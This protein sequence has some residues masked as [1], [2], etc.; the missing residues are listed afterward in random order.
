MTTIDAAMSDL[1]HLIEK[2]FDRK[3]ISANPNPNPNSSP[4]PNLNLNRKISPLLKI[5]Y[6]PP[7]TIF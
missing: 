6:K 1:L 2:T 4:K 7:L 5:L 3:R